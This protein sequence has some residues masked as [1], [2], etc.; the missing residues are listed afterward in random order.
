MKRLFPVNT[1]LKKPKLYNLL[2]VTAAT[3]LVI[4]L[5]LLLRPAHHAAVICV[6]AAAYCL[7][8]AGLLLYSFREQIRYNPYSYNTI[9]YFGFALYALSVMGVYIALAVRLI[10]EPELY[11]GTAILWSLL[12][13]TKSYLLFS[14]PFVFVFSAALCVSNI[15]LIVREGRRLVNFLGILLAFLLVGG[16]V[17]LY[18][19]DYYASGSQT[20][21]MIH[22]LITNTAAT[23]YLYFECMVI[24]TIVADAFAAKYEPEKNVDFLIILGC[25][26]RRDGTLTPLLR[27]RVERAIRFYER[28]KAQTGKELIFIPS[29]GQGADEVVSESSAMKRYLTERGI[30]EEQILEENRSA[31]TFENMKFSKEIIQAIN[32]NGN[33]AF[34]TT[35]YHVFR[36]GIFARRVKMRA[37]GMGAETKWYFWPN[38]AVREFAGLLSKHRGK[39]AL[40]LGSM[41]TVIFVLTLLAYQIIT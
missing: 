8:A 41:I 11:T 32:P 17:A 39:Q 37:V 5:L 26:L 4:A 29:G 31:S 2:I 22:D 10:R 38:A 15:A 34:S 3:A 30:P 35:N 7:T 33:V 1:R 23:I 20:E 19:F 18:F 21:V 40:L 6:L 27:G 13:S 25:G 36:S 16:I 14:F 24:G 28:Q 9:I 12:N